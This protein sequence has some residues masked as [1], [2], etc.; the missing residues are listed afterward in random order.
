MV[1]WLG[2]PRVE[3]NI[4]IIGLILNLFFPGIGNIVCGVSANPRH[5][6]S[7]TTGIITVCLN[8]VIPV[9]AYLVLTLLSVVTFGI[10][11]L[12]FPFVLIFNLIA[13]IYGIFW[14]IKCI[15]ESD[16]APQPFGFSNP[17]MV[18]GQPQ[19]PYQQQPQQYQ[20]QQYQQPQQQYQQQP[21]MY[22]GT[23]PQEQQPQQ[24]YQQQDTYQQ[25][26]QYVQQNPTETNENGYSNI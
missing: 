26:D 10:A 25:T 18:N 20:T 3:K 7:I 1:S 19:Q 8:I 23:I 24:S 9:C 17:T 4:A 22:S 16:S 14:S 6:D 12:L 15:Q 5:Q 11:G 13:W 21:Q 2:V